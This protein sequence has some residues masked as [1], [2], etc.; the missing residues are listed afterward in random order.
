MDAL[1]AARKESMRI[2]MSA[3]P[4]GWSEITFRDLLKARMHNALRKDGMPV[5]AL[6]QQLD[7]MP[8]LVRISQEYYNL[9]YLGELALGIRQR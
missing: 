9:I 4:L 6:A 2:G 3:P 1:Q 5:P 7:G 8:V